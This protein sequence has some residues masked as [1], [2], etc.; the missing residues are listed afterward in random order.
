MP[1]PTRF[2]VRSTDRH[3]LAIV[4]VTGE[5]DTGT[6]PQLAEVLTDLAERRTTGRVVVRVGDSTS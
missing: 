5:I 4:A 3:G 1:V 2:E 6:A